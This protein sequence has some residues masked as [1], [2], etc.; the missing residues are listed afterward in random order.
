MKVETDSIQIRSLH[1]FWF[2]VSFVLTHFCAGED[3]DVIFITL[4]PSQYSRTVTVIKGLPTPNCVRVTENL[5]SSPPTLICLSQLPTRS[6]TSTVNVSSAN[7]TSIYSGPAASAPTTNPSS[8][9]VDI[10]M[11]NIAL[12]TLNLGSH[13]SAEGPIPTPFVLRSRTTPTDT[14]PLPRGGRTLVSMTDLASHLRERPPQDRFHVST[15]IQ[16][17]YPP[18]NRGWRKRSWVVVIRG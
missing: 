4:P 10:S 2:S 8:S 3:G 17:Q 11:I 5:P 13:A 18:F 1:F 9:A 14:T 15:E 12:D 7:A 16:R 6:N